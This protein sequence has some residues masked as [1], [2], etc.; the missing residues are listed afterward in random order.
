MKSLKL[1]IAAVA[2]GL[3]STPVMQAQQKKGQVSPEQRIEQLEQTV[4][5]LSAD[6]KAKIK[7]IYEKAQEETRALPKEDRKTKGPEVMR[8]ANQKVRAVLNDEQKAKFD[9]Q[10]GTKGGKGGKK[11]KDQ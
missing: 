2:I 11:K 3:V 6:Q 9:A 1:L 10:M 5:T 7:D 4:G 8:A